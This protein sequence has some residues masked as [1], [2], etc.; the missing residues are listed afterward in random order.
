MPLQRG[1]KYLEPQQLEN[2]R[3]LR[4]QRL[5]HP[6]S[7]PVQDFVDYIDWTEQHFPSG[8]PSISKVVQ[9]VCSEYRKDQRYK[10]DVRYV[11]LWMRVARKQDDPVELF[12]YL[13]QNDIGTLTC[14]FYE[15]YASLYESVDR[16]EEAK[17]VYELGIQ[18]K[19]Q[20]LD[21]L[22]R[23]FQEFMDR[24]SFED[25]P[26]SPVKKFSFKK[27]P[28]AIFQDD[29][30]DLEEQVLPH[31]E[32]RL[33]IKDQKKENE[34]EKTKMQGQT[35]EQSKKP[36]LVEKLQVFVDETETL[37][38]KQNQSHLV[39]DQ[40]LCYVKGKEFCFEESRAYFIG[41]EY[42]QEKQVSPTINT[43]EA[44]ADVFDMFNQSLKGSLEEIEEEDV[45]YYCPEDDETI[46]KK[47]YQREPVDLKTSLFYDPGYL[48]VDNPCDPTQSWIRAEILKKASKPK[49]LELHLDLIHCQPDFDQ[50]Q[51]VQK[52]HG[53]YHLHR[54]QD[55]LARITSSAWEFYILEEAIK[56]SPQ[57][58]SNVLQPVLCQVFQ[59]ETMLLQSYEPSIINLLD[60]VNNAPRTKET[61]LT[62]TQ[63]LFLTTKLYELVETFHLSNLL[64]GDLKIESLYLNPSNHQ[65]LILD[66]SASI[67]LQSFPK[68]Q[69]FQMEAFEGDPSS[70]CPQMIQGLEWRLEP[71][72]YA[73]CGVVYVLLFGDWMQPVDIE[74]RLPF[75]HQIWRKVFRLMEREQ[76]GLLSELQ[77]ELLDRIERE[78]TSIEEIVHS[79]TN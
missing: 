69:K 78:Q 39:A 74:K 79:L 48:E 12:K 10:N 31:G 66:L 56:R 62:E 20:P 40:R 41:F 63:A 55:Y 46:S 44:M 61:C 70:D 25:K 73:F 67:D 2:Q 30:V 64:I 13:S 65:L 42:Q 23:K 59:Q 52:I 32:S 58:R 6:S 33:E 7:D 54:D 49:H 38:P 27:K 11:R 21:R 22:E 1:R 53:G 50:F 36:V 24:V 76:E 68:D 57:L 47:V 71:D 4:E 60:I 28:F 15:E 26:E 29:T 35:L 17:K 9:Q 43:K 37:K 75:K 45:V 51:L 8:H 5:K 77:M 19:A 72:L 3:L 18:R 14:L 34:R 16:F